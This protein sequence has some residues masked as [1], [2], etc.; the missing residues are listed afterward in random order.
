MFTLKAFLMSILYFWR[1][2]LP[3]EAY[4][5]GN[6]VEI[7]R[8]KNGKEVSKYVLD[9]Q[10]LNYKSLMKFL[11][12]NR[13]QWKYDIVSYSPDFLIK[14]PNITINCREGNAV[15]LYKD[16]NEKSVQLSSDIGSISHCGIE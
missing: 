7:V 9:Q 5:L 11:M 1:T 8:Y 3:P 2:E 6:S 15:V 4:N 14:G 10:N 12:S 16:I 13:G